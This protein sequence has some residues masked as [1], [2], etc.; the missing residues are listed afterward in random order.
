MRRTERFVSEL[1]IT[2]A[3]TYNYV[4]REVEGTAG[5]VQYDS[6]EHTVTVIVTDNGDG[7][8]SAKAE[9]KSGE[10]MNGIVFEI[11]TKLVRAG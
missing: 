2:E 9:T 4:I 8:L 3:G 1:C 6:A 10:D 11:S 7:T 5:G